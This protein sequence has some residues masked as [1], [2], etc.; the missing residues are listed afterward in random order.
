MLTVISSVPEPAKKSHAQVKVRCDCGAERMAVI[1]HLMRGQIR[2]CGGDAHKAIAVQ[3]KRWSWKNEPVRTYVIE[4]TGTGLV[5]IGQ[6]RDMVERLR[7][8]QYQ[9]PVEMRIIAVCDDNV[10]RRLHAL[11]DAHRAHGEWFRK[12]DE[13]MGVVLS[14][15]HSESIEVLSEIGTGSRGAVKGRKYKCKRCGE[16][17]HF[18]KTCSAAV[19]NLSA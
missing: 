16:L 11:L 6:S 5:K 8:M 10:E 17:G 7:K 13:V 3:A 12:N 1:N 18:A 19:A 15:C 2:S 14:L 9:C 4:A